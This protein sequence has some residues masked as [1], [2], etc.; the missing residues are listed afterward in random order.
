[1]TPI[2]RDSLFR[3]TDD[4][5]QKVPEPWPEAVQAL[6]RLLLQECYLGRGD[7][8]C[9][10]YGDGHLIRGPNDTVLPIFRLREIDFQAVPRLRIHD[11]VASRLG[12]LRACE[13]WLEL[14][15]TKPYWPRDWPCPR[16]HHGECQELLVHL[17]RKLVQ[18]RRPSHARTRR[19]Q[20]LLWTIPAIVTAHDIPR[21]YATFDATPWF[22][23]A[24]DSDIKALHQTLWTDEAVARFIA[25][26]DRKVAAFFQVLADKASIVLT[27]IS[28]P[29]AIRWLQVNRPQLVCEMG[30][31]G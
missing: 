13:N 4:L 15:F 28:R 14:Y 29:C 7:I 1:M 25:G 2:I 3:P 5:E 8:T 10:V 24:S 26:R 17:L 6:K 18:R 16:D 21:V 22:A 11:R 20:T 30:L 23:Q 31:A 19:R 27:L 9:S 12:I